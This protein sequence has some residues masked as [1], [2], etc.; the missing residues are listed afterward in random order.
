[1]ASGCHCVVAD[2]P[3]LVVPRLPD[4][5]T[6]ADPSTLPVFVSVNVTAPCGGVLLVAT[7]PLASVTST[8]NAPAVVGVP[9]IAPI[10]Y[11]VKPAGRVPTTVKVNGAVPP[12]TLMAGLLKAV[13]TTPVLALEQFTMGAGAVDASRIGS[14]PFTVSATASSG[15]TVSF[16]SQTATVCTVSV[17]TVTLKAA[18]TC[19]IQAT[20]A[21]NTYYAAATSVSQSFIVTKGSQTITFAALPNRALTAGS[22]T[23]SATASSGLAVSFNSQTTTVCTVSGTTVTLRAKGTCTIQA[24]QAGNSN[25]A[26]AASV[27]QSFTVN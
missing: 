4:V 15:L 1:M 26:A 7:T 22:F 17:N 12:V 27:N 23:V 21:G 24:T 5:T 19:T 3:V 25:Y 6:L 11:W 16:T 18:G 9:A 8:E 2:A 14:G 10:G 13:P 20:Q